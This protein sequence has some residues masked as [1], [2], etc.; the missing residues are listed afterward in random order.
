MRNKFF[1]RWLTVLMAV[2]LPYPVLAQ[3]TVTVMADDNLSIVIPDVARHYSRDRGITVN[4]SFASSNEQA[5]QILGGGSADILITPKQ[6]WIDE[7]KTQ[8]L[9][10]IYSETPVL[11]DRLALA[12]PASSPLNIRLS[13][14]FPTAQLI[15]Q[16]GW[17]PAFV[18]ANPETLLEGA[19][20]KEALRRMHA[21]EDLEEYTL[22]IKDRKL[23]FDA[24]INLGAYG[25]FLYSS[26][27]A[28]PGVRILD[29]FPED[30]H[31]PIQYSAVVIAGDNMDEARKF[32]DYL[33]SSD[34]KL[35]FADNGFTPN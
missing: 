4:T 7:L 14:A 1:R 35:V 19:F 3:G 21:A 5:A 24:V 18:V 34:A 8:G 9:I 10:D 26:T 27:I 12:G 2:L 15:N 30:T 16:M 13:Q 17:E 31:P 28:R 25:V 20:S 32:L 22:Y 29:V 23:M 33:K 6:G 11:K